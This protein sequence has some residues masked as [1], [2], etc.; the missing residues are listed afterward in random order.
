[1]EQFNDSEQI[2]AELDKIDFSLYRDFNYLPYWDPEKKQEMIENFENVLKN[3]ITEILVMNVYDN[4]W[5]G[6]EKRKELHK[7]VQRFIDFA[8]WRLKYYVL[9]TNDEIYWVFVWSTGWSTPRATEY[10][11]QEFL[12]DSEINKKSKVLKAKTSDLLKNKIED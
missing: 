5:C 12:K 9:K 6:W 1:M 3:K 7:E 8:E 11:M 2:R 10:Y 4:V